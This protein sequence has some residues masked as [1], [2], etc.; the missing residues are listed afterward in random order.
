MSDDGRIRR[1]IREDGTVA[2]VLI[3]APA[4]DFRFGTRTASVDQSESD[5]LSPEEIAKSALA[6]AEEAYSEQ[7]K[8]QI[9]ASTM[10]TL[11]IALARRLADLG[12]GLDSESILIPKHEHERA[13]GG[14]VGIACNA[15]GDVILRFRDRA[16]RP[17]EPEEMRLN[18]R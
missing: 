5:P 10:S 17:I 8:L 13:T 15:D 18:D 1:V 4:A 16:E 14:K 3:S 6:I 12:E 7:R 9:M 11:V 2:E